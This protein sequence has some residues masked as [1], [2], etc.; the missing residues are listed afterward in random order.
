[1]LEVR[2]V[3]AHYDAAQIL[4]GVSLDLAQGRVACLIGRNGVGKTT[5]LRTV[6]GLTPATGGSVTFEGAPIHRL[7]AFRVARRGLGYVPED[8]RVFADLTVE[9]NLMIAE[10][11]EGGGIDWT[12]G[13]A[14]E[15]FPPLQE[16]RTRQAGFLSGGQQQMLTIA[17]T[18]MGRPRLLLLDE[19][20]EGL[21]PLVVRDLEKAILRL[22]AEGLTMLVAAQDMHFAQAVADD[23][24]VMN[25]GE[26]VFGGTAETAR[27]AADEVLAHMAL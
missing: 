17:R 23:V 2:D 25:R 12:V 4:F 3:T 10:R 13:K 9:E 20:T 8:R 26:I 6:M 11:A 18:L 14:F 19:P 16:F 7:P 24:Y 22:K 21:S 1:M 5:T 15:V 27:E